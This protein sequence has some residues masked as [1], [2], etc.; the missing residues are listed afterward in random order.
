MANMLPSKTIPINSKVHAHT[1]KMK[2]KVTTTPQEDNTPHVA[3]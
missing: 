3:P 1:L 2:A